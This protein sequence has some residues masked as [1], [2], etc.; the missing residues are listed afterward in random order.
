MLTS[1]QYE[2]IDDNTGKIGYI[3]RASGCTFLDMAAPWILF[4][5]CPQFANSGWVMLY[6]VQTRSWKPLK[7]SVCSTD[8]FPA[9]TNS[10]LAR[11]GSG[12]PTPRHAKRTG[13]AR[14]LSS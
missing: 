13:P 3:R 10:R 8:N 1:D 7:C 5:S 14:P 4:E 2:L 9:D 12:S 6:N 11:T